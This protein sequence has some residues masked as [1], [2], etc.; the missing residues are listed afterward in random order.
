MNP[1]DA[2]LITLLGGTLIPLL[3]GIVTKLH[4]QPGLKALMNAGLTAANGALAVTIPAG[5]SWAWKPFLVYW[6]T[7]FVT[8]SATY[9]GIWKPTGV[10]PAIQQSTAGVGL[11]GSGAA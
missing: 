9:Y 7:S 10:A 4:A 11:G 5:A 6:V 1:N 3:V 8:S 2:T